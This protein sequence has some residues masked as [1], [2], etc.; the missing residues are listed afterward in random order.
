MKIKIEPTG[1]FISDD[2]LV[3]TNLDMLSKF[4]LAKIIMVNNEQF[5]HHITNGYL[6][7][8]FN[9]TN[10][11][12]SKRLRILFDLNYIKYEYKYN[13]YRFIIPIKFN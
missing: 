9:T 3:L 7:E 13:R 1:L 2:I 12:V 6:A 5:P 10:S 8:I 4:I 11:T